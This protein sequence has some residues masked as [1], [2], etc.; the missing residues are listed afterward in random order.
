MS[1]LRRLRTVATSALVAMTA[2]Y[3]V[4]KGLE[5]HCFVEGYVA[6]FDEVWGQ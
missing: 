4:V 6:A 2:L 5:P 3:I 1:D